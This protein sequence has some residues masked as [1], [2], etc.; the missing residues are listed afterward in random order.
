[1]T[2]ISRW[3]DRC[4]CGLGMKRI[5]LLALALASCTVGQPPAD[6]D[7]G[8]GGGDDGTTEACDD[9]ATCVY[10][11]GCPPILDLSG[12]ETCAPD[13]HCF[14]KEPIPEA[15]RDR[16]AECAG[17]DTLCIPDVFL[18]TAGQFQLA[19]CHSLY[20][21]EGRCVSLALPDIS[22][23]RDVLPQDTCEAYERCAPCY[24]PLDG[25]ETG[26]CALACD[27]GPQE[28]AVIAPSA[29]TSARASRRR[30]SRPIARP[31]CCRTPAR[32]SSCASPTR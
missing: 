8:D 20:E 26:L 11:A 30:R 21:A 31:S 12:Y 1:M 23:Q 25:A 7:G 27:E 14:D 22:A 18:T 4:T 19:S 2:R 32:R 13:A 10:E 16:F 28:P 29:R 17:G 3:R 6:D 15:E 5:A 24:N 9:P